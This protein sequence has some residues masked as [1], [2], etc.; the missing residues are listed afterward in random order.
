LPTNLTARQLNFIVYYVAMPNTTQA[1]IAAGYS[2][3]SAEV[4]N[5]MLAR[6]VQIVAEAQRS[7]APYSD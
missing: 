4:S 6:I 1:A 7:R 3:G 2:R 5:T